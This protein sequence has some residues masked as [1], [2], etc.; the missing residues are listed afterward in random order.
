MP[1]PADFAWFPDF[2]APSKMSLRIGGMH[3]R[4]VTL[5]NERVDGAGWLTTTNRHLDWDIWGIASCARAILRS[6]WR[7]AGRSSTKGL[8]AECAE[9][10]RMNRMAGEQ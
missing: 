1:L 10:C 7:H 5:V 4:E 3:G 8:W 6:A 2:H 9:G